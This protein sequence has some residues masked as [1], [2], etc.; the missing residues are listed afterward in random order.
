MQ[1]IGIVPGNGP[2]LERPGRNSNVIVISDKAGACRVDHEAVLFWQEE[3]GIPFE[4]FMD[5]LVDRPDDCVRGDCHC[6]VLREGIERPGLLLTE[7]G[8]IGI[9]FCPGH[10]ETDH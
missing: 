9:I 2:V 7:A 1:G 3:N 10:K 5:M 8:R 4:N 6:E